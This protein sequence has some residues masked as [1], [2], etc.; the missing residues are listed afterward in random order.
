M[1]EREPTPR[2]LQ[3]LEQ[4]VAAVELRR[5]GKTYAEIAQALGLS[6]STATA[7]VRAAIVRAR[8]QSAEGAEAMVYLEASRLDAMLAG[9][10]PGVQAGD[11]VA[12]SAAIRVSERRAKL[13]GL[14]GAVKIHVTGAVTVQELSDEELHAEL[15]RLAT[16]TAAGAGGREG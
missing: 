6:V 5:Q 12:T 13:F 16:I 4:E 1:S 15:A 3:T 9:L 10:W 8:E 11:P 14:D 7:R 2:D